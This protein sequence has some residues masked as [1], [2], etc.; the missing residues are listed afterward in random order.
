MA[1]EARKEIIMKL[2][3]RN[4]DILKCKEIVGTIAAITTFFG[5]C[6]RVSTSNYNALGKVDFEDSAM[7]KGDEKDE[8]HN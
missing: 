7:G 3:N 2:S 4:Y 8:P 1:E 6:L 5:V